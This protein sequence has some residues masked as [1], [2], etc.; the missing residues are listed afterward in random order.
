VLQARGYVVLPAGD[1]REAL[2]ICEQ[3]L[4]PIHLFLTDVVMPRMSGPELAQRALALRPRMK[5][6]YMS[7]YADSMVLPQGE[8][9]GGSAFLQKPFPPDVLLAKVRQVLDRE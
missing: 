9:E 3:H 4:G 6:L 1:V 2:R 8:I 5:V 7:G